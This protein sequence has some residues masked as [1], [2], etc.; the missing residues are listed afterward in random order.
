V[1]HI[2]DHGFYLGEHGYIGKCLVRDNVLEYLPLYTEVC[3]IPMTVYVPGC[4]GGTR[5]TSLAQ[6]VDIMPTVLDLL[7]VPKP[8]SVEGSSLVPVL[9]GRTRNVKDI[10]VGSP[11]LVDDRAPKTSPPPAA[12]RST[13]TDGEWLFI[14]GAQVK[15]GPSGG[16]TVAVDSKRH[17]IEPAEGEIRPELYN[18]RTDPGCTHNVIGEKSAVAA[19]L[20]KEYVGFLRGK[21]YPEAVLRYFQGV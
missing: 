9:E 3:R 20:Q 11:A 18:I 13:I 12:N 1:I 4:Q 2:A 21:K 8:A 6:P 7:G 15:T 19:G 10:A 14:Y 5:L 17:S 16:S